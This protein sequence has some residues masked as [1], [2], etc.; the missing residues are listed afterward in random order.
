MEE[1][2]DCSAERRRETRKITAMELYLAD[3]LEFREERRKYWI[4]RN[5]RA[6]FAQHYELLDIWQEVGSARE[7]MVPAFRRGSSSWPQLKV[8]EE[9]SATGGK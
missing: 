4:P 1:S 7:E 6:P 5:P 8:A 3:I 9:M 2:V